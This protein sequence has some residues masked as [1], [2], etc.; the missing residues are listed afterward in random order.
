MT[1]SES[2]QPSEEEEEEDLE[3]KIESARNQN[4]SRTQNRRRD[5]AHQNSG[6]ARVGSKDP[7][8]MTCRGPVCLDCSGGPRCR[9][10][11]VSKP[12]E[13]GG[14]ATRVAMPNKMTRYWA[15][16]TALLNKIAGKQVGARPVLTW[17]RDL[18]DTWVNGTYSAVRLLLDTL[19]EEQ[20]TA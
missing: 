15:T 16:R 11:Q 2:G 8:V 17:S 1:L 19:V 13:R 7:A 4:Q 9:N 10:N 20:E 14:L 6:T 12:K 18:E 5:G 3:A